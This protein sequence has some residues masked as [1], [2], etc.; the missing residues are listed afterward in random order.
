[1]KD[2]LKWPE[3]ANDSTPTGRVEIRF[4]VQLDG[5]LTDFEIMKS[6]CPVLDSVALETV[7]KMPK[8]EPGDPNLK[9][10]NIKWQI[11]IT[12]VREE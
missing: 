3:T 4:K 5:T 8:W 9:E 11:P 10:D 7:K 2:N 12:F 6:L 1:M